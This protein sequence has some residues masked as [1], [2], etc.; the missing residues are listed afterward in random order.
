MSGRG[1][2]HHL[3]VEHQFETQHAMG[4]RMLRPHRDRHL[5]VE[6]TIDNLE[7]RRNV[8]GGAHLI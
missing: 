7:L 3:A 4:R 2:D 8:Y 5:R 1:L 6:R